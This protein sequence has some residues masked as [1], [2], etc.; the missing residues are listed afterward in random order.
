MAT[1]TTVR[2]LDLNTQELIKPKMSTHE[3]NVVKD[4]NSD[5]LRKRSEIRVIK[6]STQ[7]E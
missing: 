3:G 1:T 5:R 4:G 7:V 6:E 2:C